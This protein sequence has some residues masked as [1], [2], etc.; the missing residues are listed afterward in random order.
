MAQNSRAYK[1]ASLKLEVTYECELRCVHCSSDASPGNRLQMSRK[2]ALRIL[3]QAIDLGVSEIA[4]SGGEPLIWPHLAEA[5]S[6]CTSAG[7]CV[8]VYSSGNVKR[9]AEAIQMLKQNRAAKV[10]FSVFA[11]DSDCHDAVTGVQGSFVRTLEAVK[12]AGRIGLGIEFHF[13]PLQANFKQ[14]PAVLKL[15][16]DVGA[17][18]VSLLRLVPQGR[19]GRNDGLALTNDQNVVLQEMVL[20]ARAPPNLRAG[21]PYNFLLINGS[22]RCNAGRDRLTVTPD[23]RLYPCDAFKQIR[24]EDVAGTI[25]LSTLGGRSLE[26]CWRGSPYLARVREYLSTPFEAPCKDCHLL[27]KCLSGCMA[28]KYIACGRLRK[29]PDPMCVLGRFPTGHGNRA[30]RM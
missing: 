29:C 30:S 22:P 25:E 15:A 3:Q 10:I 11:A 23:L 24:A 26:E 28:Q 9:Q 17:D 8:V 6:L 1:L 18:C 14:L 13:V 2:D 12:H 27:D 7:L 16:S 4:F 5:V 21:S 20:A 19:G